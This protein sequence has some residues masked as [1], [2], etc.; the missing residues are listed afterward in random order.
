MS[1]FMLRYVILV[2]FITTLNVSF[3]QA[4]SNIQMLGN[5]EMYLDTQR[6]ELKI[7]LDTIRNFEKE[8]VSGQLRIRL[9]F[10]NEQYNGK[11]LNGHLVGELRFSA[12]LKANSIVPK[13]ET[14]LPYF[15]VPSG[16]YFKTLCLEEMVDGDYVIINYLNYDNQSQVTYPKLNFDSFEKA[17]K[18]PIKSSVYSL[19]IDDIKYLC[20]LKLFPEIKK[21]KIKS[22]ADAIPN[23]ISDLEGLSNLYLEMPNLQELPNELFSLSQLDTLGINYCGI[24]IIPERIHQLS[25]LEY[26]DLSST[27]IE[28]LPNS[29]GELKKLKTLLASDT[30]LKTIP[31]TLMQCKNLE[32]LDLSTCNIT[33]LPKSIEML[34]NL[35]HLNINNNSIESLPTTIESLSKLEHLNIANNP[36]NNLPNKSIRKLQNLRYFNISRIDY[37]EKELKKLQKDLHPECKVISTLEI[38]PTN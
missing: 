33:E 31:E 7:S 12:P 4:Q 15:E 27:P 32:K 21:L 6:G 36:I 23:C 20:Q 38:L 14:Q 37:S 26:L 28:S 34:T 8:G 35:T 24:T 3:L 11:S 9:Y 16:T 18:H 29:I 10:L 30:E 22:R 19:T 17:T 2:L 25:N 1:F 5:A 13:F